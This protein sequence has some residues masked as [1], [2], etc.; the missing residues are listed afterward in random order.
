MPIHKRAGRPNTIPSKLDRELTTRSIQPNDP[1]SNRNLG[2][3]ITRHGTNDFIPFRGPTRPVPI[4]SFSFYDCPNFS[5]L[6]QTRSRNER[7]P[8]LADKGTKPIVIPKRSI[9]SISHHTFY[10][11]S[12]KGSQFQYFPPR[13]GAKTDSA[14]MVLGGETSPACVHWVL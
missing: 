7:V 14:N 3:S 10:L 4:T 5:F 11:V 13:P 9:I 2:L 12:C 1:V 8:K 6:S